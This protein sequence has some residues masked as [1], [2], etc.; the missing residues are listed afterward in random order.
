MWRNYRRTKE[1]RKCWQREGE[2]AR[3]GERGR[4]REKERGRE[5]GRERPVWVNRTEYLQ[6]LTP[7]R[8][9]SL[10]IYQHQ[11]YQTGEEHL[12]LHLHSFPPQTGQERWKDKTYSTN[13]I[14]LRLLHCHKHFLLL[15]VCPICPALC[16]LIGKSCFAYSFVLPSL[17]ALWADEGRDERQG[18]HISAPTVGSFF[19]WCFKEGLEETGF[20]CK[21]SHPTEMVLKDLGFC[22]MRVTAEI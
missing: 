6:A 5:T 7:H 4:E 20:R 22:Q 9:K 14:Y 11:V 18:R 19:S 15:S 12:L 3:E 8:G 21:Q 13:L 2:R 10:G 1:D 16:L 17:P